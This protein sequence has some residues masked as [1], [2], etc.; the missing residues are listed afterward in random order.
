MPFHAVTNRSQAVYKGVRSWT[1]RTLE[2]AGERVMDVPLPDD[3]DE[4][5]QSPSDGNP[6]SSKKND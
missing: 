5:E 1:R 4:D 6:E 2:R 3:E